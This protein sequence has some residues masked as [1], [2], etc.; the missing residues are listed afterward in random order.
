MI[1]IERITLREIRLPLKEPFRI[2]SGVV[3]RA[4]HLPAR[5]HRR[6]RHG[7]LVRVRRRRAAELQRRDD[8]HGVASRS[9][10]GSRRACSAA[11]SIARREC[12]R[13]LDA[14]V[15]GHNMAKAA[16]EMGCGTSRRDSDGRSALASCSAER[17][18]ASRPES[19]SAFRRVPT[20]SC[21]ARAPRY[22]AGLSQ[23]QDE[24]PAG[25]RRR[26]R[27]RR[28]RGARPVGAPDGRRELRVHAR[29][30]RAISPSSI[31]FDLIM[32]EQ[33]LGR[34]DLVRHATLQRVS[35]DAD[36]SRRVD[37]RASTARRT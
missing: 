5:A 12:S 31:A 13:V 26:V 23:D 15:C 28:A 35:Q 7:R 24:D 34:D 29:R 21:S 14:N 33:P 17:A 9:A 36:L 8:R 19:R 25:R 6:R 32:I 1:R 10:S 37:H 2:S 18:I 4:A 22:D 3:T 27:A 20:R 16:I 30:R 11:R